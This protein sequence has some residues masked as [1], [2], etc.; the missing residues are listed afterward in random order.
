MHLH[1]ALHSL[2]L[3]PGFDGSWDMRALVLLSS[4]AK[5]L[6]KLTGRKTGETLL[7][8]MVLAHMGTTLRLFMSKLYI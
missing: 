6:G 7:N 4:S 8:Y 5:H 1:C 3:R 2:Q